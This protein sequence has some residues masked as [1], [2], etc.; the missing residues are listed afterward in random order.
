MKETSQ[1]VPL[2]RE[3]HT[4][5]VPALQ[6]LQN[7][8][9]EYLTPYEAL[10]ARSGRLSGMLLDGILEKRRPSPSRGVAARCPDTRVSD[11]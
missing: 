3:D 11:G 8:G 5:Q 2:V 1:I 6:L 4:S 10:D 9:W 7:L